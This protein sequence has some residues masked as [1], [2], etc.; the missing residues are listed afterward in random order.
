MLTLRVP[1]EGILIWLS[2]GVPGNCA[3][4]NLVATEQ[5]SANSWGSRCEPQKA[6]SWAV[7]GKWKQ[8]KNGASWPL[9]LLR[10]GMWAIFKAQVT[11]DAQLRSHKAHFWGSNSS[12]SRPNYTLLSQHRSMEPNSWG[13][14]NTNCVF[15]L[16]KAGVHPTRLCSPFDNIWWIPDDHLTCKYLDIWLA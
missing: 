16:Y 8:M 1:W 12:G 9:L 4:N 7:L 15:P 11:R 2:S 5:C 14:C 6:N 3:K 10:D 13:S